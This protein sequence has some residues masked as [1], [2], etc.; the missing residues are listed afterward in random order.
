MELNN[1]EK[2]YTE[3]S[4]EISYALRHAPWEFELELDN[5]GWVLVN[6]LLDSFRSVKKWEELTIDDIVLMIE[7]SAK[8]RHE[9]KDGKI[10][11]LYGHSTPIRI[12]KEQKTPPQHLYHGTSLK[13]LESIQNKGLLPMSRQYVHLSE[14]I[15]T[16]ILVGKR[17]GD[18][19]VL[20][21]INTQQAENEGVAFYW[22]NEKVWLADYVPINCIS[23]IS[24]NK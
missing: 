16:A 1:S 10:R 6:Q 2:F 19:L 4:K 20:F 12:I 5:E 17:K 13:F 22:G 3:L 7:K 9:I 15:E 24:L 11:A 18:E 21:Q 8:K 14:D 23:I